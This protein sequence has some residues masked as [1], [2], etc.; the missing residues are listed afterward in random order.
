MQAYWLNFMKTGNPNGPNLPRWPEASDAAGRAG[1]IMW[2]GD[3]AGARQSATTQ[4]RFDALREIIPQT[5]YQ[6]FP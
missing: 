5:G 3:H 1:R 6:A 4:E 2:L